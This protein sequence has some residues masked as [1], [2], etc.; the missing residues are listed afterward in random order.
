MW[1]LH[2]LNGTIEHLT[3]RKQS[4]HASSRASSLSLLT[5]ASLTAYK[6]LMF[7]KLYRI[8][9][10]A[11]VVVFAFFVVSSFAFTQAGGESS[12]D[13]WSVRWMLLDGWLGSLYFVGESSALT[14]SPS[15]TDTLDCYS[16]HCHRV[17]LAP[18]RLQRASV[19]V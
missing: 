18:N 3:A 8:L 11:V 2:A 9:L 7:T 1:T 12:A 16:L 14:Y 10:G 15:L 5:H 17:R 19:H 4:E 13:A 6:K